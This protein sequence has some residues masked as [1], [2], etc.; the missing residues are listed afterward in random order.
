MSVFS[1]LFRTVKKCSKCAEHCKA[2]QTSTDS[3]EKLKQPLCCVSGLR[4]KA[5]VSYDNGKTITKLNYRLTDFFSHQL[6]LPLVN[7]PDSSPAINLF[8][9]INWEKRK[10]KPAVTLTLSPECLILSNNHTWALNPNV[11]YH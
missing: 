3:K 2:A 11:S 7:V 8:N 9:A 1:K 10:G 5:K 4:I 6:L